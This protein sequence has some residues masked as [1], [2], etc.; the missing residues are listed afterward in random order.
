MWIV[1]IGTTNPNRNQA[2]KSRWRCVPRLRVRIAIGP[3]QHAKN[4]VSIRGTHRPSPRALAIGTAR[5]RG[6]H[7]QAPEGDDARDDGARDSGGRRERGYLGR[8]HSSLTDQAS[9]QKLGG[10]HTALQAARC[11]CS[12]ELTALSKTMR[13]VWLCCCHVLVQVG[14]VICSRWFGLVCDVRATKVAPA[15]SAFL[16]GLI[17]ASTAPQTSCLLL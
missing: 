6:E 1:R 9:E 16:I 15:A 12:F 8:V 7:L 3:A 17:G 11:A 14:L 13:C 5:P 10:V 4:G 2:V